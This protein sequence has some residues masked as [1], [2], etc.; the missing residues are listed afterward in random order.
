MLSSTYEHT[1]IEI[2]Q[3]NYRQ[4]NMLQIHGQG[5]FPSPNNKVSHVVNPTHIHSSTNRPNCIEI[6]YYLKDIDATS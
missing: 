6:V 5:L 4:D 3:N 1:L 2:V